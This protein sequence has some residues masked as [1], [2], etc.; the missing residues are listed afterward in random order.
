MCQT[1]IHF[2]RFGRIHFYFHE[3]SAPK[4]AE[5]RIPVG[6][7]RSAKVE[8]SFENARFHVKRLGMILHIVTGHYH[9][10]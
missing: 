4:V 2:Y 10:A 8:G 7:M 5:H 1:C 3:G 6:Y 9:T